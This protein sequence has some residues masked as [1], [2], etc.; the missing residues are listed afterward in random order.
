MD[1][2]NELLENQKE[3]LDLNNNLKSSAKWLYWIAG[4]SIVNTLISFFG[5]GVS[6][7]FGLGITQLIDGLVY[8]TS[9]SAKLIA[10]C[11][12]IL[13]SGIFAGLGYYALKP[14]KWALL[15]GMIL[16]FL[17]G[18]IFLMVEDWLSI[19]FHVFVLFV[20]YGGL[21]SL[22]KIKEIENTQTGGIAEIERQIKKS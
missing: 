18:L 9:T 7:L 19:G 4:L 3:L 21:N 22:R 20:L 8:D 17:D 12:Q 11:F 14:E 1:S 6:F 13:I 16:Y 5:G 15:A 2:H 10:L